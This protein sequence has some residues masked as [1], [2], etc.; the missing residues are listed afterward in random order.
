MWQ[1]TDGE[2]WG[3]LKE[4]LPFRQIT[5]SFAHSVTQETDTTLYR[6]QNFLNSGSTDEV[7]PTKKQSPWTE[8]KY[9]KLTH[10]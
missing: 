7:L 1:R 8:D 2:E 5:S 3:C 6:D 10:I 9:K 4:V